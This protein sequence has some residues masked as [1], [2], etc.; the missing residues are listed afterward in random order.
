MF[1]HSLAL[2]EGHT[3]HIKAELK[4]KD[5]M[6]TLASP[7]GT[8]FSIPAD[9]VRGKPF[10]I[11][12]FHAGFS[13]GNDDPVDYHWGTVNDDLTYEFRTP[14]HYN[15][16]AYDAVIIVYVN[17]PITED[18][19]K[20]DPLDA[21]NPVKGDLCSFTIDDSVV[22]EGDPMIPNGLV[23]LNVQDQDAGI[24]VS[25]WPILSNSTEDVVKALTNT[26]LILP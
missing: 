12:I 22:K 20:G 17:T 3:L 15:N 16:G 11:S 5:G 13:P 19:I 21:P 2:A 6:L 26:V 4:T 9:T 18:I 24:V 23:R 1:F 25:N 10:V 8:P 14:A 7:S